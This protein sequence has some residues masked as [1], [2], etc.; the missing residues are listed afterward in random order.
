[1]P[2]TV[3]R[4]EEGRR[5]RPLPAEDHPGRRGDQDGTIDERED[6]ADCG[7]QAI[8]I[9]GIGPELAAVANEQVWVG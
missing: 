2:E 1:M 6:V 9:W 7:A 4:G 8:L 5:H 3:P